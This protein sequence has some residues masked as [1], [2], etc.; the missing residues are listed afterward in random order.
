MRKVVYILTYPIRLVFYGLIYFYKFCI[1]PLLPKSCRFVPTCSTY[2]L[3]AIKEYGII[4]GTY[5][6]VWRI[7][8]CNHFNHDDGFDPVESNIKGKIRWVI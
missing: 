6:S 3:Q 7:L 8:R 2:A 5:M 1:S 4:K